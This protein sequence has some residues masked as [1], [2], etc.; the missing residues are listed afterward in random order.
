MY[1]WLQVL[2]KMENSQWTFK[3]IGRKFVLY[4]FVFRRI[5]SKALERIVLN[6]WFYVFSFARFKLFYRG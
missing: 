3:K 1:T 6:D 4:R 5:E 2:G